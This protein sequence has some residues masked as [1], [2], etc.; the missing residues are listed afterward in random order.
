MG[1]AV[2]GVVGRGETGGVDLVADFE[3]EAEEE[4]QVRGLRGDGRCAGL[5]G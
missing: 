5:G 2:W 1:A 3:G 4:G